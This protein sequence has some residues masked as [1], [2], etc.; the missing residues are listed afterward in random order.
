M[1]GEEL[2][3]LQQHQY[4]EL[5]KTKKEL[6]LLDKLYTLYINVL[7]KVNGYNDILW[8]ELDFDKIAEEVNIFMNQCKRLPKSLR[9]WDAFIV[10]KKILD[11]FIELQP[12]I[13]ELKN[14]SVV[15]RHWQ[16]VMQATGH[17][18]KTDPDLFRLQNLVDSNMLKVRDEVMDIA[19]SSVREAEIEMKFRQQ[20]VL[21]KDQELKFAEFKH[22]GPI[23]LKGDDTNATKEAL[24]ESS[25]AVNSMLSSRY[26][27]FMR[28]TIQAFLQKLVKVSETISMW[29]EVQ[30]TWMYLEAVFAGGDIMKQLPQEA[31][32]FAAIDKSWQKIMNKANEQ[33]N[34]LEFCYENELLQNLPNLKEQLDECQRKLSLYLEQKRNLF[35]R[36]YFVS[37]TVLLEILSQASDPQSIQPH[38]C[39]IF[40]GLSTVRFERVKPK[41]AGAQPYVQ[42]VEMFSGEG[43]ALMMREPM[44]CVGNVEDWLNRLC[45]GMCATVRD[46]VKGSVTELSVLLANPNHLIYVIDRYPAQVSLLMLQLLWTADVTE[47][48]TKGVMKMK[49]KETSSGPRAKCDNVKTFLVNMTTSPEL[50]TK[51]KRTRTNIETLITIQVV[52]QW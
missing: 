6:E 18:W 34:V 7:Q 37:D 15:E 50:E 3:G 41:E 9:E 45:A 43:E 29:M 52:F 39:S 22:R 23:I 10:L 49:A 47:C 16:Q 12:I 21:W 35:P 11:D 27:A 14:E 44:P 4:P 51:P 17:K 38:L 25:L 48:I 31:K 19:S 30:F 13:Q 26:C 1:A 28:E 8:C 42:I 46:V 24:E 36:F 5:A 40:D 32:R 33:R 2:F 20:E